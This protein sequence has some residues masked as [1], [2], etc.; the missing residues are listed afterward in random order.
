MEEAVSNVE[1]CGPYWASIAV[2]ENHEMACKPSSGG[3]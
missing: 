1:I 2:K 3:L